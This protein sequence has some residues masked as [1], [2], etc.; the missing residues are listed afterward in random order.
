MCPPSV[1]FVGGHINAPGIDAGV[2]GLNLGADVL[3]LVPG[4]GN[5]RA[6]GF[7][8]ALV[9]VHGAGGGQVGDGPDG[10]VDVGINVH[11]KCQDSY[12]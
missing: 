7:Q 12:S 5:F 9:V 2:I 4:G 6:G 8:D 10:A 11:W 3:Q 1:A